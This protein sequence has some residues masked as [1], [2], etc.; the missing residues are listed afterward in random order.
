[1][2]SRVIMWIVVAMAIYGAFAYGLLHYYEDKPDQLQWD[3]R[4][5][6]NR[7]YIANLQLDM[8]DLNTILTEIGSPDITEAKKVNDDSYQ[9]TFYRTQHR[10]SDGKTTQD[11][12]TALLFKNGTLIGIG[13]SAY[14][15][16]KNFVATFEQTPQ[17]NENEP[18]KS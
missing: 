17:A 1:M 15:D 18:V 12:C 6:F 8:T 16:F 10:H 4:E 9:V 3:E 2:N 13:D 5:G 11:E 7:Q 14:Q